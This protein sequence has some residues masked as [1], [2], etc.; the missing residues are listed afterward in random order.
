MSWLLHSME[1]N[2]SEQFVHRIETSYNMWSDLKRRFD[3]Q[4]NYAHIF[5]IKQ[6]ITQNSKEPNPST[7]YT[8]KYKNSGMNL[9]FSN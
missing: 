7:S 2:I 3:K 4:D 1:S 8:E 6:E 5:K 9:M